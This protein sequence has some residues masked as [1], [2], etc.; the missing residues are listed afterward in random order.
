MEDNS[1]VADVTR[2]FLEEF[3]YTVICASDVPS[4]RRILRKAQDRINIVL[5]DIVMP[6]GA[7]GLDLARWIR[8]EYGERLPV[9]L[10]TGY[11]NNAQSAADEGFAILRKPYEAA[12]LRK[13]LAEAMQK[14]VTTESEAS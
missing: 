1:E 9:V 11:A 14:S 7:D 8:Q 4:A 2:N 13:A 12:E 10:A 3:G 5:S 6:G